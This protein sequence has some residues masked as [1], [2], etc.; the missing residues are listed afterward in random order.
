V[1]NST[2][3]GFKSRDIIG[4]LLVTVV[5]LLVYIAK[6]QFDRRQEEQRAVDIAVIQTNMRMI[7]DAMQK[8][9]AVETDHEARL[10]VLEQER[11]P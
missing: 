6:P 1:E 11:K 8:Y 3:F 9:Q 7:A 10:R 5:G 4:A 2:I